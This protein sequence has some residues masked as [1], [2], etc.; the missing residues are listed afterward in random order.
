VI[1]IP[2]HSLNDGT[3]LPAVGLGTWPMDDAEAEEAV[4]GALG[5]GFRLVDTATDYRD[6]TGVGRGV[7][8]AGVARED[9]VLTTKP[10]G[11][12]H[13]YEETPASLV[14]RGPATAPPRSSF[15]GSSA[16]SPSAG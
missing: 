9:I 7:T 1:D 16:G 10:P 6:E 12:H 13:G 5:L 4:A 8:R 2:Q 15:R 3:K 11:R 14:T